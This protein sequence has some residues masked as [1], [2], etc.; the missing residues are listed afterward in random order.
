MM[1]AMDERERSVMT[2]VGGVWDAV[3]AVSVTSAVHGPKGEDYDA[4]LA[5][6]GVPPGVAVAVLPLWRDL[7][8]AQQAMWA[9]EMMPGLVGLILAAYHIA[10]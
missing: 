2:V 6:L 3:A 7:S 8:P 5:R 4:M 9:R 1:A 10:G